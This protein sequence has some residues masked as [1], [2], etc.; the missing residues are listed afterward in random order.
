M[1]AAGPARESGERHARERVGEEVATRSVD[2]YAGRG[3]RVRSA[4]SRKNRKVSAREL[5]GTPGHRT[6]GRKAPGLGKTLRKPRRPGGIA[7]KS[8]CCV[9]PRKD[10]RDTERPAERQAARLRQEKIWRGTSMSKGCD[11]TVGDTS[12]DNP[13]PESWLK[14][15]GQAARKGGRER[16]RGHEE[17]RTPTR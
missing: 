3:G 15:P 16:G 14:T 17:T 11:E 12:G 7:R 6:G 10:P 1:R 8:G 2:R 4:G 5:R 9:G 13:D